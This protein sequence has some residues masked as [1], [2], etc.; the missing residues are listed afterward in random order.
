[1]S[2]DA[3]TEATIA[4]NA[5][6]NFALFVLDGASY[7]FGINLVSRYTIMPWFISELTDK[8]WVQGLIPMLTHTGWALPA[9]FMAPVIVSWPRR[10]RLLQIATLGERIP[11]LILGLLLFFLP[12]MP[13]ALMLT[14]F[15]ILYGIQSCSTGAAMP[16]WQDLIARVIPERQWGRFFG[17]QSGLGSLFGLGSAWVASKFLDM[18][19]FPQS[20]AV[21]CLLCFASQVVSYCLLACTVEPPQ[22]T[23]PRQPIG[24]FL[25]GI[26]PLIKRDHIFR[27]YLICR[28]AIAL[29]FV[30]HNF[31][32]ASAIMQF[33]PSLELIG[34]FTGTLLAAQAIGQVS[35]GYV[36]DR[37]GHKL[38][39]EI[40]TVLGLVCL[41]LT[42]LAP[43]VMWYIPIFIL[44]G[45]AQ[46]GY[47]LSGYTLVFAFSTPAE[48]PTYIGVANSVLTPVG[49]I[50]PIV[51]GIVADLAGYGWMFGLLLAVGLYG[52][53]VLHKQVPVPARVAQA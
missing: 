14:I 34:W 39:F 5:P 28:T 23:K 52:L 44:M 18:L 19:P 20:F 16:V 30:G 17:V 3:A 48:R 29:G 53:F 22:E 8:N 24:E 6:R 25:S 9:L 21:L 43:A 31:L 4:R 37:Y 42:M 1:M 46:S 10:K 49:A 50:G 27:K 38:V 40:S 45:F 35:L 7:M 32:T 51:A 13:A 2:I 15:F 11:F 41:L 47:Q 36:A 33:S 12:T 26:M